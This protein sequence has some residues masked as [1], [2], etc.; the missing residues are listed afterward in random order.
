MSDAAYRIYYRAQWPDGRH[1]SAD[2]FHDAFGKASAG[3][4]AEFTRQRLAGVAAPAGECIVCDD[5][6][7]IKRRIIVRGPE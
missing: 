6:G 5:I 3:A 1:G 7:A 4:E 2:S